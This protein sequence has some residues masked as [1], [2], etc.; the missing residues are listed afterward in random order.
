MTW[1]PTSFVYVSERYLYLPSLA[2]AAF[3]GL[4]LEKASERK[5]IFAGAVCVALLWG[6]H[7]GYK[8]HN[9]HEILSQ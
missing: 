6:G 4:L 9:K 5:M 2:V 1:L 8:L 7:Q 3:A